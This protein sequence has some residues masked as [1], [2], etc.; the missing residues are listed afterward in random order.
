L[1]VSGA[2]PLYLTVALVLEEGLPFDILRRLVASI[3]DAARECGVAVVAGDTKVVPRG[4]AD[5]VFITTTGVGRLRR[6]VQLGT[7]LVRPGDAVLVSGTLGDHGIAIL[8]AREGFAFAGDLTSDVAP[9]HG[10]AGAL[11]VAGVS[12]RWMRDLTRGGLSAALHELVEA[13]GVAI[14]I[15]ETS[16]PVSPA[17][18]GACEVLGLD[19]I[20]VANEGKLVAVVASADAERALT[21]LRALPLGANAARVGRVVETNRAEV[22]VRSALGSLRVLDEPAGAPLPRIC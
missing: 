6:G 19:P 7:H 21:T 16:I 5:Q 18:R 2:E 11:H 22:V 1:A 14:E 15:E 4:A 12:V 9:L 17:V 3:R 13:A 10:L 20:Y 8:N